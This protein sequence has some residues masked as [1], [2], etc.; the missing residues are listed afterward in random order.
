MTV[1][2][3]TRQATFITLTLV[4]FLGTVYSIKN[5]TYL[6]TSDPLLTHLPHPLHKSDYFANKS[7]ILNVWF[8]KRAWGW[9]SLAFLFLWLT[10]PRRIQTLSRVCQWLLASVAWLAF[11]SWFFGPALIERFILLTGGECTVALPSGAAFPVSPEY[12]LTKVRLSPLTHPTLFAA[13][14]ILPDAPWSTMPRLRRGHDV[15]GHV[16]LLTMSIL[17]LAAQ[18]T[19]SLRAARWPPMHTWAV[20]ATVGLLAIWLF[21][22]GTTS[23]YF[24]TP[25][26]KLTGYLLGLAGYSLTLLL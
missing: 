9:T 6:D 22:L 1:S 2:I 16:F 3:N 17:F 19:P 14:L 23:V 25:L 7:N 20:M 24:H 15:S 4:L 11:T 12:C 13:P 26:E 18:L 5:N 10:S 8:I 21:A